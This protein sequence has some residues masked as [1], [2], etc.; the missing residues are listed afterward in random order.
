[1][2][3]T[4]PY[5]VET[6][7]CDEKTIQN[8]LLSNHKNLNIK[9]FECIHC[10]AGFNDVNEIRKHMSQDHSSQFLFVGA[11]Q[12][13]NP[14]D[15]DDDDGD[16]Q[17]VYIGNSQMYKDYTLYTCAENIDL[18]VMEP[19]ELNVE[20]QQMKLMMHPNFNIEQPFSGQLPSIY[21][22]KVDDDFFITYE[23]YINLGR[24]QSRQNSVQVTAP[25]VSMPILFDES[26]PPQPII[27][28]IECLIEKKVE[29]LKLKMSQVQSNI[30]QSMT[31]TYK[32]IIKNVADKLT[33][34]QN[35]SY[36]SQLCTECGKFIKID[37][38]TQL[39]PYIEHL[40]N[41]RE[42]ACTESFANEKLTL[43]H[44]IK[45]HKK[46]SMV[47]LQEE[48]TSN[49][50]V[51]KMVL[52]KFECDFCKMQFDLASEI[53]RHNA[54]MHTQY[55]RSTIVQYLQT[56]YS[57]EQ[58]MTTPSSY[59]NE[60]KNEQRRFQLRHLFYCKRHEETVGTKAEAIKHHNDR[61]SKHVFEF[62]LTPFV[63]DAKIKDDDD[64]HRMYV[65]EC[66][67]CFRI[68][69]SVKTVETHIE[70]M[71][72]QKIPA[73]Y[74]VKKLYACPF[75]KS[76]STYTALNDHFSAKHPE[77][78][79]MAVN[80]TNSKLCGLC[81]H[82]YKNLD[83]LQIHFE[84]VHARGELLKPKLFE[85]IIPNTFDI[86]KCIF[87][88]GCCDYNKFSQIAQ[89]VHHISVCIKRLTCYD[90]PNELFHQF[91]D[92]NQFAIHRKQNHNE[93]MEELFFHI[94]N[95]K[96]F[97]NL[98]SNMQIFF[99]NGLKVTKY[100]IDDTYLGSK[101]RN[102]LITNIEDVF[103]REKKW[104]NTTFSSL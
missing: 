14:Q 75:D 18:N 92:L 91:N 28:P 6:L 103:V 66:T 42:H 62:N 89:I 51:Y 78:V 53:I 9:E 23:K 44:R 7:H 2:Q 47:Y 4:C 33:S 98:C 36:K 54:E 100:A 93:S 48:R 13:E 8:H 22:E 73:Q 26:P 86:D 59:V 101:I 104:L 27:E 68:F 96:T 3:Y 60:L 69:E 40:M 35:W 34:I 57:S 67:H 45:I 81:R 38:K 74:E 10:D 77:K 95:V 1:M 24:P 79:C 17:I 88:I 65:F 29:P 16:I 85:T 37:D 61:H 70:N 21:F 102:K 84:K 87:A 49:S 50:L 43:E 90:C 41:N 72:A 94:H 11:R 99:P 97:L 19:A 82:D 80:M 31:I 55:M 12:S 15:D 25:D 76:I 52:C 20:N 63:N 5:C 71:S 58:K 46:E 83:E 30:P 32:C 39:M 56:I 64:V